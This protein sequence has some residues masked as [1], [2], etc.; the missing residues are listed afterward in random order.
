MKKSLLISIL[1]L[2]SG[3]AFGQA[4]N[5]TEI[6]SFIN[7]QHTNNIGSWEQ[8]DTLFVKGTYET[9][10]VETV[11]LDL[12]TYET[13]SGTWIKETSFLITIADINIGINGIID[14]FLII[15]EDY[16]I[17]QTNYTQILQIT[18]NYSSQA[19]TFQ[20]FFLSITEKRTPKSFD[21]DAIY[22]VAS[23]SALVNNINQ[24]VDAA[25]EGDTI[26]FK[27]TAYDFQNKGVIIDKAICISGKIPIEVDSEVIGADNVS[28]EFLN[29][30]NFR[31]QSNNTT[32]S[33]LKL[34]AMANVAY[35]FFNLSN[36]NDGSFYNG[37]RIEN[38]IIEDANIALFGGNGAGFIAHNVSFINFRQGG[39]YTNRKIKIDA[40]PKFVMKKCHFLPDFD[41]MNFNVRAISLDAGNTEYPVVW[42]QSESII[43]S[44]LVDGTGFGIG[45]KT[46]H[47]KVTNCHFLGYRGDVDMIHIEEFGSHVLIDGN[48]FEH[49]SPARGINIDRE[50]QVSHDITITNNKWIGAYSWVI[51]ANSPYNILMENNDFSEAKANNSN[52]ITFDFTYD[53]GEELTRTKYDL[54]STN[55]IFRNNTG[56]NSTD[57]GYF[58]YKKAEGDISNQ[59]DYPT[60]KTHVTDLPELPKEIIDCSK[61]Y[62]IKNKETGEYLCATQGDSNLTFTTEELS[63]NT[64]VWE[65]TFEYPYYYYIKNVGTNTFMEVYRGYTMGDYNN[66]TAEQLIVEHS[67]WFNDKTQKPRW[68]LRDHSA[69]NIDM[70]EILPGGNERKSRVVQIDQNL[71][72]EYALEDNKYVLDPEDDCTWILE[73]IDDPNSSVDELK[74]DLKALAYPIPAT[75]NV[76]FKLNAP[77]YHPISI[78]IYNLK[79]Q[80]IETLPMDVGSQIISL[81]IKNYLSGIYIAQ[82]QTQQGQ[83]NIRFVVSK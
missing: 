18:V 50:I 61:Q 64:E 37:I 17:A 55:I 3:L 49:I 26:L 41:A 38:T 39:Y 10:S 71:E 12:V 21:F 73:D 53:H 60:N 44:C 42:N 63:D 69:S 28:T 51:S 16:F 9:P 75:S 67:D 66:G 22:G 24:A 48:I 52:D 8:S 45:S 81:N 79:G 27:S 43:D 1:T 46:S 68:Y 23:G 78:N 30:Q 57:H 54:P 6:N 31:I 33:N 4:L 25:I 13:S 14:T 56:L 34:K 35:A 77:S 65:F 5:I 7:P 59:I 20:N 74:N 83:S 62:R 11:N 47:V 76:T 2:I 82:I 58:A 40:A 29:L 32:I 80:K 70:F 72:L 36:S 19:R 15:P